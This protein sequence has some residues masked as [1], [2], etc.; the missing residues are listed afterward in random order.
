MMIISLREV[1]KNLN[2]LINHSFVLEA[3]VMQVHHRNDSEAIECE[4][5]YNDQHSTY[6]EPADV[7]LDPRLAHEVD[8]TCAVS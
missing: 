4:S 6:E 8:E 5:V 2:L 1:V 7:V 3:N